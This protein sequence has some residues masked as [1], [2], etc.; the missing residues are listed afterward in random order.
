MCIHPG[1]IAAIIVGSLV[2]AS[3]LTMT[4]FYSGTKRAVAAAKAS[5]VVQLPA[6]P[7]QPSPAHD[8]SFLRHSPGLIALPRIPP[9]LDSALDDDTV[10]VSP[11]QKSP[12][13][14]HS[15]S[16]SD[17]RPW[18]YQ[19][20]PLRS[21]LR[22]LLAANASSSQLSQHK[23]LASDAELTPRLSVAQMQH[24]Y[25]D[26]SQLKSQLNQLAVVPDASATFHSVASANANIPPH[27]STPPRAATSNSP[28]PRS[29]E[30]KT[31]QA[32]VYLPSPGN[33][34][35]FVPEGS[36]GSERWSQQQQQDDEQQWRRQPQSSNASHVLPVARALQLSHPAPHPSHL[37]QNDHAAFPSRIAR[38]SSPPRHASPSDVYLDISRLVAEAYD[39]VAPH[40]AQQQHAPPTSPQ[41]AAS[42]PKTKSPSS[43]T[44]SSSGGKR[45]MSRV[46]RPSSGGV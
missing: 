8:A 31:A 33:R 36:Y 25:E 24:L 26:L 45:P 15:L 18:L 14:P 1:V 44:V 43:P 16:S 2:I 35:Q 11:V 42:P 23:P 46:W 17:P 30:S 22:S 9:A 27:R 4:A 39:A 41:K 34:V 6:A 38:I 29:Q 19:Q 20:D 21:Q 5:T 37:D 13:Y 3:I 10:V 12:Q 7:R 32:A 28:S 40:I